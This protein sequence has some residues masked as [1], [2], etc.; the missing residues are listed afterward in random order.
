MT[1][2]F[3]SKNGEKVLSEN[4]LSPG[5]VYTVLQHCPREVG[6]QQESENN[7]KLPSHDAWSF[8]WVCF[9]ICCTAFFSIGV[10]IG[11]VIANVLTSITYAVVITYCFFY[12]FASFTT[13]LPW[14]DCHNDWNTVYCATV[15]SD[16][17]NQSSIVINNGSCYHPSELTSA[18]LE[19]YNVTETSPGVYDLTYYSDPLADQR[20]SES[21]EYW[22]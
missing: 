4:G 13:Y 10:A 12:L 3:V 19:S 14:S 21:E 8:I 22:T 11:A 1:L 6:L 2:K 15:A 17:L 16:C 9:N 18:E 20:V 7:I 5:L